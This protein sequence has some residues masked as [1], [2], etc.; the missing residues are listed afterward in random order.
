M[1]LVGRIVQVRVEV[2]HTVQ[3][4][5]VE[6]ECPKLA[7]VVALLEQAWEEALPE[8][9]WE[10]APLALEE[11]AEGCSQALAVEEALPHL[12]EVEPVRWGQR[13]G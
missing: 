10:E 6:E 2:V 7:W 9:A 11:V 4:L 8:P 1:A 5:A 3:V 12:V 13:S